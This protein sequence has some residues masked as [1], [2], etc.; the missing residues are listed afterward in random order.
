MFRFL[1]AA[2]A[3]RPLPWP[4]GESKHAAKRNMGGDAQNQ[5]RIFGR[6]SGGIYDAE[7]TGR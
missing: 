2:R 4:L 7:C 1:E 5:A 3:Q 6:T